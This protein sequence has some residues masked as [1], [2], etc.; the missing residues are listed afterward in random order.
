MSDEV[1][2]LKEENNRL[3]ERLK[4]IGKEKANLQM[5]VN[6][7]NQIA[8]TVGLD[9]VVNHLLEILVGAIG[10]SNIS[11]YY[12]AEGRWKYI[13]TLG[14]KKWLDEI[15]DRLVQ[16]SV[17]NQIFIK[18]KEFEESKLTIPGFPKTYETWVYPLQVH[19]NFFGA[20]RLQGMAIEHAHYRDNIDPFIQYSAL[21]LYHEVS[22]IQALTK[23]YQ[24]VQEAKKKVELS[25]ERFV[26]AMEFANDG[27]FD[28]NL[29]TNEI[30]YSPVWKRMLG[31]EDHELPNDFSI[32]ETHTH[33]KDVKRSWKM[34][35]ELIN[36]QRDRFE[37]EFKMKHKDGHWVDILSRASAI[38]D[39]NNNAVRIVGTHVDISERKK[40]ES[41]LL[42]AQKM[43]SIG[44][45]AG[46]IA[47]DFNNILY[48]ILGFTQMSKDDLPKDHP[49]QENLQDVLD[50]A[51]RA[52]DLVKRILM[53]SRQKEQTLKPTQLKPVIE[54]SLKLL[55]SSIPVNIQIQTQFYDGIDHVLCDETE[56]HEIMMNLCT[57][58]Y[59]AIED[60]DGLIKIELDKAKP[61]LKLDLLEEKYLC[62]SIQ[63]NG[64]GITPEIKQKIFDP[65]FT[66]KEIGK[67]SGLGLS[68]VHG[69]VK[70]YKGEIQVESQ[71][72]KGTIFNIFLPITTKSAEFSKVQKDEPSF[73]GAEKIL[74]VDD[75]KSI[76]KL[77]TRVFER[78]GY[79][80]T[81][82]QDSFKAFDM[83]KADPERYDLII[84]DMAMP[85]LLGSDLAQKILNIRP[86]IPIILC[87]G[88]S[89]KLEREK[90]KLL[91]VKAFIDKPILV[92]DLTAKVRE[93]L[94]EFKGEHEKNTDN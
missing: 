60:I 69:I 40:L 92:K 39:E 89:E 93:I 7:V 38:F 53:F 4:R 78:A 72:G 1:E 67:G 31:Y 75:E 57:N 49:V 33:P 66:T 59:H 63:D 55:R 19:G 68:V 79:D 58:A 18:E 44:K 16:E 41:Q 25:R 48:P 29:E 20:V 51:K 70:N 84:T 34:Q 28:W 8:S 82:E 76:V 10:G 30:Y 22:N 83:F 91:N 52:R 71:L 5:A 21:V 11:I 32:W 17:K 50:G 81:G 14:R 86:D 87:S 77:V 43:E 15:D 13:D 26:L 54:E 27:L 80:I 61:P 9:N 65:Y 47:H 42:Q 2:D 46:G 88:Y 62:L 90:A 74:F 37:L 56:I 23:A 73:V 3:K 6:L 85:G 64:I 45:L 94:D 36:K 12:E 35:N 24:K